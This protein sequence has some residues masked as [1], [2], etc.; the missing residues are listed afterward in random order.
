MLCCI[1][2]DS[3]RDTHTF[4]FIQNDQVRLFIDNLSEEVHL[5]EI[6][7]D[8]AGQIKTW[9]LIYVNPPTLATW[10]R[11]SLEEIQGKTTDEIF[12]QGATEHYLPVVNKVMNERIPHSFLDYFPNL[13][14]H[15]RFTT[16]PYDDGFITTGI[17]ISDLIKEKE[18]I[19]FDK[20]SLEL[21]VN[22]RTELLKETIIELQHA[23]TESRQLREE[24]RQQAIRDYLT[25][26]FNRRFMEEYF[27]RE[28][29]RS[30]RSEKSVGIILM[31]IDNFKNINDDYGHQAG[32][33]VLAEIGT[34]LLEHIR[35]GDAAC[36]YGG[37][38]FLLI[39]P[40]TPFE[41]TLEKAEK[42]R[43]GIKCLNSIRQNLHLDVTM[44][45]GVAVFPEHGT[46]MTEL[47]HRVDTA[48]Y[49]A[50]QEGRD[51]TIP[52]E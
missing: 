48:L 16:I 46:S 21:L 25:G 38:E 41:K 17:D 37:E 22:E 49:R 23:L 20:K 4:E 40:E 3:I 52:A 36:R 7:R 47:I 50:K 29:K 12:G 44:S 9:R 6:I 31:D 13:N 32:D 8:D 39:L 33:F 34:F 2:F 1:K 35:G 10:G 19:L 15:F 30:K 28:I 51:R 24:L 45:L 27:D 18:S 14:K 5:W 42:I 26:L 11:S 43:Q